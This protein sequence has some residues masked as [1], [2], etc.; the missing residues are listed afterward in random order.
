MISRILLRP[1]F[2]T[3]FQMFFRKCQT[4]L[5]WFLGFSIV[6][7]LKP[8]FKCFFK[9]VKQNYYD[10]WFFLYRSIFKTSFQMFFRSCQTGLL[11]FLGFSSCVLFLKPPFKCFF[12]VSDREY[13]DYWF[14]LYRSIFKTSIQMFFRSCQTWLLWLLILSLSFH[15]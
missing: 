13:Y 9:V 14:F 8:P 6:P 5:L 15:F 7:F 10:Y 1:L 3:S 2:K 12:E 11:W 4:E